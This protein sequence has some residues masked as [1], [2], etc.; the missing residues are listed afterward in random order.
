MTDPAPALPPGVSVDVVWE[1]H[2]KCPSCLARGVRTFFNIEDIPVHST[3]R[4]RTRAEAIDSPR[5]NLTL[6]FCP[7]CGFVFNTRFDPDAQTYS[8]QCEE[9]QGFSP[10]FN[11]FA[12]SLAA[13]LIEKHALRGKTILE[14]GCGKG[15]FLALLCQ[16]GGN[17]G[18]GID[19]AYRPDRTPPE[20]A[21]RVT[22]IQDLYGPKHA[23]L[24][25]DFVACRHTL[26]HIGPTGRFVQ[27]IRA[28]L[29][30][31]SETT[32]WFELPD[33][34]RVLCEGAFSDL[35]YEHCAYFSLGSL[36]R[37]F[38]QAGFDVV[39]I[40]SVY[41]NQY[42]LITARPAPGP[43]QASLP[44]ENDLPAMTRAIEQFPRICAER[45][46]GWRRFVTEA[47]HRGEKVVVWGSLSKGVSFLTTL[48]LVDEVEYVVD[49]NPHRQG[50]YMPG[51]GQRIVPPEHLA[52]Y[53]PHYVIA[54]NPIY[55]K[56]IQADLDRLGVRAELHTV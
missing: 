2:R 50:F 25:A 54:M 23:H 46:S 17:R 56:E 37:L 29:D 47:A 10:T 42:L 22:F 1:P 15:E 13:Q 32:V 39:D 35:Y 19:P 14:I 41:D 44:A 28:T 33:V 51:T 7:A 31:G 20:A 5:G 55:R 6:G 49:I 34:Y 3:L 18:I 9:S 45:L 21:D 38:R 12:R 36:A 16:L 4:M 8:E 24:A 43:T 11:A 52:G 30:D 26:E 27:D 48:K 53:Q 40:E